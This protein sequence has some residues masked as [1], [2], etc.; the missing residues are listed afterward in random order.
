MQMN[1]QRSVDKC[2][3][4]RNQGLDNTLGQTRQKFEFRS[5]GI[6]TVNDRVA[7]M[8]VKMILEPR[9]EPYSMCHRLV[10]DQAR[11]PAKLSTKFNEK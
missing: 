8:A 6:P 1:Y 2:S 11:T 10:T 7:Q 3:R 5:G 4:C 9:L